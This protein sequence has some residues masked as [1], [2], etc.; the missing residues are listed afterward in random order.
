MVAYLPHTQE[1]VVAMLKTI[2]ISST[3]ELFQKVPPAVRFQNKLNL[4]DGLSEQETWDL[5]QGLAEKNT[6]AGK[7]LCFL[8]AG[9]YQH[10]QPSAVKHILARSEFYTAYTPYQPEISQGTLQAIFEYQTMI[11]ELTGMDVSNASVYDGA[12]AVC[13]A[14]LI[15]AEQTRRKTILVSQLLHPEYRQTLGTYLNRRGLAIK[16]IPWNNGQ[17]SL[18]DLE[19]L[20]GP[21]VA[22]VIIQNPNFFGSLENLGDIAEIVHQAGALL[23]ACVDPISLGILESPGNLGADIAVGEGQSLGL[24]MSYGGPYLGFMA[25]K[26]KLVRRLP[27]RIVGKTVDQKG[28]EGFVLTLQARE[29]HIRREK[30]GSNICSNQA[31]CALAA[32]IY[33]S[34]LGSAGLEEVGRQCVL[35]S[36]YAKEEL[37]KLPGISLPFTVPTMKE[38]VVKTTEDPQMINKRLWEAGILGGLDLGRFYPELKNHLLLCVT[39]MRKKADIDQLVQVWG[40]QC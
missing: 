33:L 29:Q 27:G 21:D 36:T 38:F 30:A 5:L 18:R 14:A 39:E 9:S 2:G 25:V 24:P 34:L 35:K 37:N 15:A 23:I 40:G 19:G 1:Q 10:Y 20:L 17:T 11:C 32:G 16:T 3:E 12:T 6:H 8:G 22:G 7:Y 28:R 31:L 26:E 4:P 13:D